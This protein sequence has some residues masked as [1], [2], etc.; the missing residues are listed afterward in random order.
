MAKAGERGRWSLF[1]VHVGISSHPRGEKKRGWS[2]SIS[3]VRGLLVR[4]VWIFGS[5]DVFSCT[6]SLC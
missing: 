1:G 3:F 4:E 2:L 5:K 6:V